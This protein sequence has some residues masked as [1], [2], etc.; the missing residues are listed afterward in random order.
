HV[1]HVGDLVDI[2][3]LFGQAPYRLQRPLPLAPE[4]DDLGDAV[5]V[6]RAEIVR[7]LPPDHAQQ[8]HLGIGED[9][10]DDHLL[11][12]HGDDETGKAEAIE[13]AAATGED[14]LQAVGEGLEE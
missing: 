10:G 12:R 4:V 14:F 11:I 2:G 9:A 1:H 3:R 8:L 7:Q 6:D 13:A 5:D